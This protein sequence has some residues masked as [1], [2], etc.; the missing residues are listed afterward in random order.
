M[1]YLDPELEG[2]VREN[3]KVSKENNELLHK[4]W[5][6][7]KYRRLLKFFYLMVIVGLTLGAYYYVQPYID[8]FL[9][10]YS[11]VN[12]NVKNG[13]DTIKK[14]NDLIPGL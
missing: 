5:R 7:V 8:A 14:I 2:L 1:E 9:E 3:L 4:L 12:S 13:V 6:D 11:G 10:S